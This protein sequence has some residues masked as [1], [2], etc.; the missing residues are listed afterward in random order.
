LQPSF[1]GSKQKTSDEKRGKPKTQGAQ[2]K[3]HLMKK[4]ATP[5]RKGLKTKYLQGKKRQP[6]TGKVVTNHVKAISQIK[7]Q[8]PLAHRSQL[9]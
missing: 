5:K 3:R 8:E 7:N 9:R 2:N 4:G 6:P 1:T